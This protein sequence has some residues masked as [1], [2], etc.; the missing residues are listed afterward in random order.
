MSWRL[1][2]GMIV[3]PLISHEAN[4]DQVGLLASLP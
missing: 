1:V 4:S 2:A 3:F